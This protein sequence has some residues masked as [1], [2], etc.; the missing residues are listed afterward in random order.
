MLYSESFF[1]VT[2]FPHP[3]LIQPAEYVWEGLNRLKEYLLDYPFSP[4][5]T[6]VFHNNTPLE[7]TIILHNGAVIDGTE[8]QL[9][10]GDTTAGGLKVYLKDELLAGAS[11]LMAGSCFSGEK[12]EIGKGVLVECG[13]MIKSPI[14]VGDCNEIRQGAY[15]RG[16]IISGKGCVLGHTTEIKHAIFLNNA[17]AG[18]FNYIGDSI[19]GNNTNLGAGTKF[20]NLRF[21]AGNIHIESEG[22]DIDTGRKKFGA[23][24]GDNCQTGCNSVTNPGTILGQDSFVMP[25]AV[26]RSGFHPPGSFI[27][28]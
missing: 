22:R 3:Q 13:A 19:L 6:S 14:V 7:R 26:A 11:V 2:D 23:I 17:K 24:L 1:D 28:S 21:V 4:L 12:I 9:V 8:A 20:A 15:L 27:R 10:F 5:F 25:N 18:H 16:N